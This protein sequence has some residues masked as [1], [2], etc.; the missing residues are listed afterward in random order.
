MEVRRQEESWFGTELAEPKSRMA[1]G[2]ESDLLFAPQGVHRRLCSAA[3][4]PPLPPSTVYQ[5]L[6]GPSS[7][8][9]VRRLALVFAAS[10][11][12]PCFIAT[13]CRNP[14]SQKVS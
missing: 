9:G 13:K 8:F 6:L 1:V 5:H 3:L 14:S 12:C 4:P 2:A 10:L 11:P 7:S